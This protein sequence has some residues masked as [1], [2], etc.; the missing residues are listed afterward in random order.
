MAGGFDCGFARVAVK[1]S[2]MK[3]GSVKPEMDKD[4][5]LANYNAF[6]G[7]CNVFEQ[8]FKVDTKIF[9]RRSTILV[10][11][12]NKWYQK[13]E[14]R[15]YM[16]HFSSRAWEKLSSMEKAFHTVTNCKACHLQH[17]SFQCTF[18]I[19][20]NRLKKTNLLNIVQQETKK[21]ENIKPTISAIKST[22]TEIYNKINEPFKEL[23]NINFNEAMAK[24]PQLNTEIKK[25][26]AEKKK[27]RRNQAR[28][29]KKVVEEQWQTMD[30]ISFLGTRQSL[31]QRNK[32]RTALSM[33][34]REDAVKRSQKR[35]AQEDAGE[36]KP[37]RHSP[38]PRCTEFDKDGLLEKV[39]SMK[40]G[41]KV[42]N[43]ILFSSIFPLY[44]QNLS[45]L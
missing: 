7:N 34:T 3:S 8:N 37:K 24:V 36:R 25:S 29:Q 45:S 12:F 10:S 5:R 11:L 15:K 31:S 19:R 14:K 17:H 21:K 40:K 39:K 20:S 1:I 30:V 27:T 22:A 38:D 42:R 13:E 33:E 6:F 16:E 44:N 9:N 43:P 2:F 41:D 23:F 18:P 4:K 32:L 26:V 35:K 28:L